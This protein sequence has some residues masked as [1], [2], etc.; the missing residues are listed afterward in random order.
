MREASD[1]TS[2][3]EPDQAFETSVHAAV[4]A[5]YDEPELRAAWDELDALIT[6]PGWS[7]ALGQKLIQLTMPG[8]PDVFQGSEIWENSLV[9]PDN[10]RP[11]D[12]GA[13]AELLA[14]VTEGRPP[15]DDTGIAKLWVTRQALRIRRERPDW[16]GSYQPVL[17]IG[18]ERD[19]LV[20][21]DRGGAITL[22]TRLPVRLA[23]AGSWGDTRLT[24]RHRYV[25]QL[26]GRRAQ[27]DVLLS[28]LLADYPVALLAPA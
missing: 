22:A 27:G 9:D 4:D 23:A 15:V 11:V 16:F 24:L 19:H 12:F 7:N 18:S 13:R 8:V 17:G 10:R 6:G 1:G 28:E 3:T 26:T 21:F 20:G 5:A 2:W 25:D 14:R